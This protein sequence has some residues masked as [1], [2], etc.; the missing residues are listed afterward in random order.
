MLFTEK[1]TRARKLGRKFGR[2]RTAS[3]SID[4]VRLIRSPREHHLDFLRVDWHGCVWLPTLANCIGKYIHHSSTQPD[5]E[6]EED[7]MRISCQQIRLLLAWWDPLI[8][9]S[10]QL[11]QLDLV[12]NDVATAHKILAMRLPQRNI[13]KDLRPILLAADEANQRTHVETTTQR[14]STLHNQLGKIK[15]LGMSYPLLVVF[16]VVDRLKYWHVT[17]DADSSQGSGSSSSQET[18]NAGSFRGNTA[19]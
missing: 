15:L 19:S 11:P 9:Y 7:K 13:L 6:G 14:Y 4:E 12:I 16:N 8:H 10:T 1:F 2:K 3:F 18:R 5:V 17:Y